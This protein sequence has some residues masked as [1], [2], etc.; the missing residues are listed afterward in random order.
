MNAE[1]WKELQQWRSS[2]SVRVDELERKLVENTEVTRQNSEAT[3][4]VENNTKEVVEILQ[5]WMGAMKVLGLLYKV[6][7]PVAAVFAFVVSSYIA[8]KTGV[9]P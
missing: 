6:S 9:K 5:S 4:R 8:W 3:R 2:L 7:K 1:D